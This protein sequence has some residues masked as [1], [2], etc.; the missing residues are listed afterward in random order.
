MN[1]LI[2]LDH[3]RNKIALNLIIFGTKEQLDEDMLAI[4]K[5]ELNNKSQIDTTYLIE[6]KRLGKIIDHKDRLIYVKVSCNGHKYSILSKSTSLKGSGIFI[7]EDLIPKDQVEVRKEVQKVKEA[8]KEGKWAIIR[9]Q[10]AI[11]RDRD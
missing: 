6:A 7:N 5:E 3:E 10:K 1:K 9:N 8:R 2:E 11:V 4:V